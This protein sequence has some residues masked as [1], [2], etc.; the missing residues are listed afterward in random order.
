M[1][2]YYEK[3]DYGK[4]VN[5]GNKL[6]SLKNINNKV[7]TEANLFIARSSINL[8]DKKRALDAYIKLEN[9]SNKEFAVEAL[10]FKALDYFDKKDYLNSNLV[11]EK[12]SNEFNGYKKWTGRSLLLMSKNFDQLGDP[13][14]ASYIL[15]SVIENFTQMPDIVDEAKNE[16]LKI[17]QVESK[18]NSSIDI[19][20]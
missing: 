12:I 17:R 14:Q 19:V 13:F 8:G 10:Y 6:L 11:I 20:N 3:K 5:Y 9:D 4:A 1:R 18:K 15:E 16:L 2:I 7:K